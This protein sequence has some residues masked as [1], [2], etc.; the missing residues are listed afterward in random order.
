MSRLDIASV[1]SWHAPTALVVPCATFG[2]KT[3]NHCPILVEFLEATYIMSSAASMRR[4]LDSALT[5]EEE[6]WKQRSKID[7]L[8]R[9]IATL[10]SSIR[11]P[12][13]EK[14][15]I[16]SMVHM[17][18][19]RFGMW[20]NRGLKFWDTVGGGVTE[21]SLRC[22]NEGDSICDVNNTLM[23]LISKTTAAYHITDFC[24]ISLCNV[25]YKIVAKALASRLQS[26]VGEVISENQSTFVLGPII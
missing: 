2:L 6:Y 12:L 15:E 7:W 5:E 8:R 3:S 22:L 23:C 9:V 25:V 19:M 20:S 17:T 13:A 11:R 21:E 24:T 1:T 26:V 14:Q 4:R 18:W 16:V 10:A